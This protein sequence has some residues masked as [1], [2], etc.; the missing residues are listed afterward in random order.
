MLPLCNS[1]NGWLVGVGSVADPTGWRA[2]KPGTS[3]G[4]T[5]FSKE[6]SM[7]HVKIF[8]DDKAKLS[9]IVAKRAGKKPDRKER[10]V[11]FLFASI[12]ISEEDF[13]KVVDRF[14]H[15]SR[16]D[17]L[18]VDSELSSKKREHPWIT[19]E[20]GVIFE[21]TL[22]LNARARKIAGKEPFFVSFVEETFLVKSKDE[23]KRIVAEFKK[24]K[25]FDASF[26]EE[27]Y[28][29]DKCAKKVA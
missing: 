15:D 11:C 25:R 3:P 6:Q 4:I 7:F 9:G 29:C 18:E 10:A 13:F 14:E 2:E 20:I 28:I 17:I 24:D 12:E 8:H 22:A 19:Y 1:E 26:H 27:E 5:S 23:A 21:D 16:F